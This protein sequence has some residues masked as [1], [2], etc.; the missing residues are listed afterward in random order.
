MTWGSL[1]KGHASSANAH[2]ATTRTGRHAC[3]DRVVFEFEDSFDGYQVRYVD[4]VRTEP[5]GWVL[6]VTGGAR[7]QVT[8]SAGIFDDVDARPT[9]PTDHVVDVTGYKTLRDVEFGGANSI[10]LAPGEWHSTFGIGVRA[11]LPFRAFVL[12]GPGTHSRLV[13]DVAHRW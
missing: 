9:Y 6:P 12:P 3:Y 4:Q 10:G 7:L 13:I 5:D 1:D 8:L 11:R 2:L